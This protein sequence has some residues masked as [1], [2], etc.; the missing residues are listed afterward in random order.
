MEKKLP[1]MLAACLK[2]SDV[3]K[4]R[5]RLIFQDEARFGRMVRIRR[6]WAQ[7][8]EQPVV[9]NQARCRSESAKKSNRVA[10]DK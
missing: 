4:R 8:P 10:V 6:C 9:C 1:K 2:P 3:G 7:K 5:V